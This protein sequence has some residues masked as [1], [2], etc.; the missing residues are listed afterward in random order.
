MERIVRGGAFAEAYHFVFGTF[1]FIP[2]RV[3]STNTKSA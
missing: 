2:A 1:D 3:R